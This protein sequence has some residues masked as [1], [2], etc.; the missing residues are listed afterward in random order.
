MIQIRFY[1]FCE[2]AP[3]LS[4][5]IRS[6]KKANCVLELETAIRLGFV[7]ADGQL[8]T[9]ASSKRFKKDVATTEKASKAI[10]A[11]LGAVQFPQSI[12][13]PI[14]DPRR[15]GAQTRS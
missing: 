15:S 5:T 7:F 3:T 10:L 6:K 9:V 8:G 4:R 11:L 14:L 12:A 13:T 2:K 1:A